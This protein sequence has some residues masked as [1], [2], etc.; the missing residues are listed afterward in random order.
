[1]AGLSEQEQVINKCCIIGLGLIGG[2]LGLALGKA[3]LARERWGSDTN[4]HAMEEAKRRG[5][6]EKTTPLLADAVK[7][8][9]LVILS[10]PVGQIPLL[11][12]KIAPYL[13]KKA[14]VTDVGSSKKIVVEA[15]Q[16]VLPGTCCLGG[17]PMAG[18]E[19]SG[20]EA[21]KSDLFQGSTYFLT[22][23]ENT[24]AHA[25]KLMEKI[26]LSIGARPLQISPEEHDKIIAPLSHL[27]KLI[28]S[29]LVNTLDTYDEKDHHLLSLAGRGFKDT[30][31]IA[32]GDPQL[33]LD[34]FAGNKENLKAS[35]TMFL[36]EI[37]KM[38]SCL[39]QED[40]DGLF[41]LLQKAAFL[42]R[43]ISPKHIMQEE[44]GNGYYHSTS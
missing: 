29:A 41:E 3:G 23:G 37:N 15:M 10:A 11:L 19:L 22:P 4:P 2:S 7:D 43:R 33:W 14:L 9:E 32:A 12:E 28:S 18:S 30:T 21:A 1:M 36:E 34:I 40:N 42:R 31:R 6:A 8:A 38:M 44:H 26:I 16:T 25:V 35:L 17:H 13:H 5:A 20:M 27:P 39:D 24:S